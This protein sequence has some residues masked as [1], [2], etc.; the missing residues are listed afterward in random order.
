MQKMVE[1]KVTLIGDTQVGKSSF[2][3]R[4]LE[5]KTPEAFVEP[6]VGASFHAKRVLDQFKFQCW[7]TA[8]TERYDSLMPMYTRSAQ[9]IICMFDATNKSSLDR[10]DNLI[11]IAKLN[12]SPKAKFILVA[13][14]IDMPLC[15]DI[16]EQSAREFAAQ[17]DIQD[18]MEISAKTGQGVRAF[19]AKMVVFAEQFASI[20]HA[21]ELRERPETTS[22][23][24][25]LAKI[26]ELERLYSAN[27]GRNG[28]EAVQAIAG[29]LRTGL[30]SSVPQT[31]F[32]N[33]L[34]TLKQHLKTLQW[35]W[36]SVLNTVLNV[37][38]SVLAALSIV[39]LPLL[40]CL[41]LWKPNKAS[42]QH[43]F[44]LFSFGDKQNAERVSHDVMLEKD[45]RC[46]I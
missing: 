4:W 16:A 43:S 3:T 7:D 5:D 44:R 14:K 34:T 15:R 31:Y 26:D 39:G 1:M 6:T 41:N 21:E 29:I 37:V 35:T 11:K 9:V 27:P 23:S 22:S 36:R 42:L 8:G 19:Q 18:Y 30:A 24:E 10:L 17:H 12:V 28:G 46:S 32:D 13:N 25:L 33:E 2:F 40:Y 38:L 45:V 20:K